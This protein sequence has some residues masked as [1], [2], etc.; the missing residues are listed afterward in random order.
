[1]DIEL[2]CREQGRGEVLLLLH[3]NGESGAYFAHQLHIFRAAI[4]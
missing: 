3:G 1:M 4:T 2:Y